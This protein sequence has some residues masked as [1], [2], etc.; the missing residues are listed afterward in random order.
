MS[1]TS[2]KVRRGR[3]GRFE[4]AN[5]RRLEKETISAVAFCLLPN[6]GECDRLERPRRWL[7]RRAGMR[8][9]LVLLFAL[10]AVECLGEIV[11]IPL[12]RKRAGMP[13]AKRDGPDHVAALERGV[14]RVYGKYGIAPPPLDALEKRQGFVQLADVTGDIVRSVSIPV[15][16]N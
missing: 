3:S 10:G 4:R 11:S 7:T 15:A 5:R 12:V 8:S 2:I 6:F 1:G 9:T 14:R 16:R 13:L